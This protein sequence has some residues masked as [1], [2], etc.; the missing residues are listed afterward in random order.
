M[1]K[2]LYWY[3]YLHSRGFGL[4]CQPKGFVDHDESKGRYGSVAY[5]KKLTEQEAYNY[6]LRFLRRD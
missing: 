2:K 6:D 3:E 4:G 5:N 1:D